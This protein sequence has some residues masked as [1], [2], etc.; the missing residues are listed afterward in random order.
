MIVRTAIIFICALALG[1]GGCAVQCYKDHFVEPGE[2]VSDIAQRYS[3]SEAEL[4]RSNHLYDADEVSDGDWLF[5][6]C[7]AVDGGDVKGKSAPSSTYKKAA[8]KKKTRSAAKTAKKAAKSTSTAK[9]TGRGGPNAR[10]AWPLKGEVART[11]RQGGDAAAKGIDLRAKTGTRVSAAEGG[12]VRYAG[13]PAKGAYGSMVLLEHK[14][15]FFT[16]YSQL[17]VLGVSIGDRL[18]KGGKVGTVG[19]GGHLHF[20]VRKGTSPV[21]PLLFLPSR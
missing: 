8:T 10:L 19:K 7:E 21:D 13:T 15:N 14:N 12:T 4:R 20:E 18:N 2:S 16:V 5:V 11:F 9:V 3:L 17:G 6:P 1:L